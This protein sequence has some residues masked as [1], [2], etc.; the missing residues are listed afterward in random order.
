MSI[1]RS[2]SLK[3]A[4]NRDFFKLGNDFYKTVQV[5]SNKHEEIVNGHRFT[6]STSNLF[7]DFVK[8]EMSEFIKVEH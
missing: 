1:S 7:E 4:K 6:F 8:E 3:C 2:T 5:E